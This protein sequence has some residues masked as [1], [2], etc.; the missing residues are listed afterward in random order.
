MPIPLAGPGQG[1]PLPQN[2]YPTS[3]QNAPQDVPTN[4]VT[5]AP[6]DVLAIPAGDWMVSLGFYL[7]LQFLD[8]VTGVWVTST[9]A[10]YDRGTKFISADGF[11][12]R[13][14]NLTGCPVSASVT[15][16]G[17]GY[18]QAST[19]I[20][21]TPG[22]STWLPIVGGQLNGPFTVTSTT[23]GAGYGVAPV[24]FIPAPPPAA[25]N[26]NGVG[27]IPATAY[28]VI[29]SGTVTTISFTNPGAGYPVAPPIVIL[30]SPFDPNLATGITNASFTISLTGSGSI[31]GA[32]CTNNG[33]PLATVAN[34][35]LVLAGAGTSG[36]LVANV[37]QTITNATVAGAGVGYGTS[38]SLITSVGGVP[39]AGTITNSPEFNHTAW[40]PRPAQ[41]GL[42]PANTSVSAGS[43]GVIYDGGLFEGTPVPI[44]VTATGLAAATT[45]ATIAFVMGNVA[46]TAV[47]Q[48]AP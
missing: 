17:S 27:G 33:A 5:L 42:T 7:V 32:L 34:I 10:S 41:I 38:Q 12:A 45:I 9:S 48:P 15:A 3:L 18:V 28:A 20:T 22:G 16:Y 21:A 31:T 14:A 26:T 25:V 2:L 36:S 40:L 43:A 13:I 8:P 1:L 35:S 6:G 30:P 19:T 46:D 29:T 39:N 37:M 11:T 47:M 44:V 23:N 4:R 24:V